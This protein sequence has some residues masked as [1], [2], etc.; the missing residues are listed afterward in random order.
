MEFTSPPFQHD[1]ASD[2]VLAHARKKISECFSRSPGHEIC[3]ER[4]P[5]SLPS[6]VIDVSSEPLKLLTTTPE[7]VA[8]YVALS[9]C[10]GRSQIF[11]TTKDTLADKLAGFPITSLPLT[12]RD[13]VNVTRKLGFDYLWIDALC[14]IQDSDDDKTT[15]IARMGA[16]YK[17]SAVTISAA[18]AETVDD[19]FLVSKEKQLS[20]C[21]RLPLLLPDGQF[22]IISVTKYI[23]RDQDYVTQPL[24]LRGWTLQE[25]LLSPR[26]LSFE[27]EVKW[28]CSSGWHH[29]TL[30][31]SYSNYSSPSE[32]TPIDVHRIVHQTK[33]IDP[34][35]LNKRWGQLSEAYNRRQLT[36]HD[37][38][39]VAVAGI[40]QD[41][42]NKTGD[43]YFAGHWKE[44]LVESLI[45]I[46]QRES[47]IPVGPRRKPTWSWLSY[48]STIK[49]A[50]SWSSLVSKTA[51]FVRCTIHS[52]D[53]HNPFGRITA[54]HLVLS[55]SVIDV[56][57]DIY[58]KHIGSAESKIHLDVETEVRQYETWG[59]DVNDKAFRKDAVMRE[60][61]SQAFVHEECMQSVSHIM[62]VGWS[63]T[64]VFDYTGRN[65]RAL[66]LKR[67]EDGTYQRVGYMQFGVESEADKK[68]I[69]AV[70][71][72]EITIV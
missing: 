27:K 65:G 38:K 4:T 14:I 49:S 8:E 63:G 44:E 22:G 24:D 35:I 7:M 23:K 20:S 10:W 11:V 61:E 6:R 33:S 46:P 66:L 67:G 15:E 16:I 55:A 43:D 72:Q 5:S 30:L 70:E 39:F 37:D 32:L 18:N 71:R 59:K 19:G 25:S 2:F 1:L 3:S 45:W 42:Q 13:A 21:P 53:S 62:V 31:R 29:D 9:Y 68:L 36:N 40:A 57:S 54:G 51:D 48:D 69:N 47:G 58:H 56:R 52:G 64:V 17:N 34:T 50:L 28:Q 41:L 60:A 12:L 26:V